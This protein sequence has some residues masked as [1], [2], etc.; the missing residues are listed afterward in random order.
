LNECSSCLTTAIGEGVCEDEAGV[1][2]F[3]LWSR[4]VENPTVV[5]VMANP[6]VV[7]PSP[8]PARLKHWVDNWSDTMGPF[9][10]YEIV[11]LDPTISADAT[12]ATS[13]Y[14]REERGSIIRSAAREAAFETNEWHIDNALRTAGLVVAAWGQYEDFVYPKRVERFWTAMSD[15]DVYVIGLRKKSIT[16]LLSR[17]FNLAP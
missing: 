6:S 1:H 14:L 11:N 8:I 16:A 10:G 2:R 5:F 17:N 9:G 7:G 12:D 13:P 4:W 3:R 15:R